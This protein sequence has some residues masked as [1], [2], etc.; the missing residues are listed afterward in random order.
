MKLKF[1]RKIALVGTLIFTLSAIGIN[2][3][4]PSNVTQSNYNYFGVQ[5]FGDD[6]IKNDKEVNVKITD[7]NEIKKLTNLGFTE[8]EIATFSVSE[9]EKYKNLDGKIVGKSKKYYRVTKDSMVEI[10]E[11]KAKSEAEQYRAKK[12][13]KTK[14]SFNDLSKKLIA[15]NGDLGKLNLLLSSGGSDTEYT[16]WLVLTTTVSDL[17]SK[18]FLCKN[19]FS[20]MSDAFVEL[21]DVIG[22]THSSSISVNQ[23][24]EYLK[25]TYEVY[26]DIDYNQYISTENVTYST[27]DVKNSS[28]YAFKYNLV[29]DG[30]MT[31]TTYHRGYMVYTGVATP[32]SF[33]GY[34]NVYGHY[35]HQQITASI[36]I[37]MS[38]GSMSVTPSFAFDDAT[39][40]DV[41]F[42]IN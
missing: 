12:P 39:D 17:G 15:F 13:S 6:M 5:K 19:S 42:Y 29:M 10:T 32:S 16:S 11:E 34:S 31:Y 8:D 2:A 36:G 28:G 22:M 26:R 37:G 1:L 33:V 14:T 23:N 41:Q 21:T 18:T 24:S 40:T 25:Y 7:P 38:A 27:A 3:E 35:S 4:S 20:W 9:Y 30:L